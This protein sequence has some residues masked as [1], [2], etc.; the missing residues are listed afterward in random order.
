MIRKYFVSAA[1]I[2]IIG[3]LGYFIFCQNISFRQN[4]NLLNNKNNNIQEEDLIGPNIYRNETLGFSVELPQVLTS[5]K[6][7]SG[8]INQQKEEKVLFFLKDTAGQEYH[9][10]DPF[11]L[12]VHVLPDQGWSLEKWAASGLY[13]GEL[14]S[15][16]PAVRQKKVYKIS[17]L[18]C[19]G[20]TE[21]ITSG[22]RKNSSRR[23][24]YCLKNGK[25][26]A[27]E[28]FAASLADFRT[29][30]G[31]FEEFVAKLKIF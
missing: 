26:Y 30:Q 20:Q 12:T 11:W 31:V 13:S 10:K 5:W 23:M 16:S 2:L 24:V 28:G 7:E 29:Y 6:E 19:L 3:G 21:Q 14:S 4:A 8:F 18:H 15:T 9:L 22:V 25:L 1:V 17:G 27:V